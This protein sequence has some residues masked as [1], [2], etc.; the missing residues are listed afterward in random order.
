MSR[1]ITF[2]SDYGHADEFA[3]VCRAV[4]A[5]IA[6]DSTIIDITH[7]VR[8][9][10]VRQ[11]AILLANALPYSDPASTWPWSIPGSAPSAGRWRFAPGRTASWSAPTTASSA[12][13]PRPSAA[14]REAVDLTDSPL[15]PDSRSP[16]PSTGA[17]CSPRSAPGWPPGSPLA[18][19]R[20][21][22]RPRDP[23]RPRA[24]PAA[25]LSRTGWWRTSST[26]DGFGNLALDLEHDRPRGTFLEP[27]RQGPGRGRRN[28]ITVPFARTFS[29]VGE[30]R[31]LLYEDSARSLALAI[32]RDSAARRARPRA[33]RR[34]DAVA[35]ELRFGLP[36][37][38]HRRCD[39]TNARAR[40]L[41]AAG[42][43]G[44]TIVT[45][46]EQTGGRGRQGRSWSA[47]PRGAAALLGDPATARPAPSAAAAGRAAGRLR[48]GRGDLRPS[49]P[50]QVAERRLDRRA[51]VRRAC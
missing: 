15:P 39:S 20:R 36:R 50:D 4:M 24:A 14:P 2:L 47:P 45:A 42:A 40:E 27:G 35:G 38:H 22:P 34:G 46:D 44:G 32:N 51:Q 8:R 6:P 30:G 1:P 7:G 21:A 17:T 43:P 37:R 13:P 48:G 12:R 31:G 23:H 11:G 49:L 28:R 18:R 25:D 41:A 9:H 29:D 5:R 3:G 16:R 10:A 19:S 33:R 26:A